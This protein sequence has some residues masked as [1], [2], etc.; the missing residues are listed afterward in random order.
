VL[1]RTL[2]LSPAENAATASVALTALAR[3]RT[4]DDSAYVSYLELPKLTINRAI[5]R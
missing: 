4:S 5:N 3:P 1:Q 2:T